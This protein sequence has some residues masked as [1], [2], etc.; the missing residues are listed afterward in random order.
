MNDLDRYLLE[1]DLQAEAAQA[2]AF[3]KFVNEHVITMKPKKTKPEPKIYICSRG[4]SKT[5]LAHFRLARQLYEEGQI[6]LASYV[7]QIGVYN[8]VIY[9]WSEEETL[10]WSKKVIEEETGGEK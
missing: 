4:C 10:E 8:M 7:A 2:E 1:Q 6:D 9:G 3:E 5:S